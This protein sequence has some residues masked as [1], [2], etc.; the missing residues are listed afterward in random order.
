MSIRDLPGA[1]FVRA[2]QGA[3]RF[4]VRR[5][6]SPSVVHDR[7]GRNHPHGFRTNDSCVSLS[8]S[9]SLPRETR[10]GIPARLG[11]LARLA[12]SGSE[13]SPGAL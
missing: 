6:L 4:A 11:W 8:H 3:V 9:F 10:T 7:T 5:W 12:A 13:Q 1:A 2:E